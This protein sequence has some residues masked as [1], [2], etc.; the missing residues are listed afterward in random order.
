VCFGVRLGWVRLGLV[1]FGL[2]WVWF[3]LVWFGF[4]LVWFGF[5]KREKFGCLENEREDGDCIC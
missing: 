3:G 2:V 4:G 1:W 5:R